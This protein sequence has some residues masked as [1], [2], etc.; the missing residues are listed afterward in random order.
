MAKPSLARSLHGKIVH[1]GN[2]EDVFRLDAFPQQALLL[3]V[4]ILRETNNGRTEDVPTREDVLVPLPSQN[5][6]LADS[7][8]TL[9]VD[10]KNG[11]VRK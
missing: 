3:R 8:R 10:D 1:V 4:W 5:V 2:E 6:I 7:H 9:Q 11:M